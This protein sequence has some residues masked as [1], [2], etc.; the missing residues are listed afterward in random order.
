MKFQCSF[1]VLFISI[2]S[3]V[4]SCKTDGEFEGSEILTS[5]GNISFICA[6]DI[7]FRDNSLNPVGTL[8]F[9]EA[10]T[11]GE[12]QREFEGITFQQ[13]TRQSTGQQ[14][15]IARQF[16]SQKKC[17][18][19]AGPLPTINGKAI[20]EFSWDQRKGYTDYAIWDNFRRLNYSSPDRAKNQTLV[21]SGTQRI[22]GSLCEK[23]KF[24]KPCFDKAVAA[25][26]NSLSQTFLN[27]AKQRGIPASRVLMAIA[28]QET[29]LGA[30]KDQGTNGVGIVQIVTAFRSKSQLVPAAD[31][32]TWAGITHNILTNLDYSMRAAGVK[33][34]E[35]RVNNVGDLAFYYNGNPA[36]QH[37]YRANVSRFYTQ[38]QQ[39]GL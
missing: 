7:N 38:L 21:E 13:I 29:H 34:L 37:K 4:L 35:N 16:I 23:A 11:L 15:Y 20:C 1:I 3:T 30:L 6:A 9:G 17:Q 28:E 5:S 25:P 2:L 12:S 36:L 14:G 10:V 32:R 31:H 27:W 24:L 8:S 33:I 18:T 26:S 39:C 19:T 22:R